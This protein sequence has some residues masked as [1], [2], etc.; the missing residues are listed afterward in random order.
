MSVLYTEPK[1]VILRLRTGLESADRK[2]ELVLAQNGQKEY[3]YAGTVCFAARRVIR[4]ALKECGM[5]EEETR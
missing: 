3:G 1:D 5:T 2:L 4:A